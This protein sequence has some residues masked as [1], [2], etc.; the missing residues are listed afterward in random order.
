MPVQ[1]ISYVKAHL[2]EAIANAR[3]TGEPLRISQN[4]TDAAV[5]QDVESYERTRRALAL[6]KLAAM[7]DRDVQE[8]RTVPQDEVF[9]SLRERLAPPAPRARRA[10]RT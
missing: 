6:L 8:G 7:G 3:S 2:A 10:S 9:R 1:T 5:L 4:G